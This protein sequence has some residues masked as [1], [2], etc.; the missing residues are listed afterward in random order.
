LLDVPVLKAC[1]FLR[2]GR[3]HVLRYA[4]GLLTGR[5]H[6]YPDI[7]IHDAHSVRIVSLDADGGEEPVQGDG[8]IVTCLPVEITV[9]PQR[10]AVVR[11]RL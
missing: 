9:S 4:F 2:A 1:L 7:A 8:D 10:L 5:L 11:P 3:W 6:R